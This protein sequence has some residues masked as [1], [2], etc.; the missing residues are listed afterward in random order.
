LDAGLR[1]SS[2]VPI[3]IRKL[4]YWEG[5]DKPLHWLGSSLDDL[6]AFP[7]AAR[8]SAGFE[9]R[10]LQQGLKPTDWKP[11]AAVGT[12]VEEIRIHATGAHRVLYVARFE[13]AVYVLHGFE[14]KTRRAPKREIEAARSRLRELLALRRGK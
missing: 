12:G 6:R 11:M 9:L 1:Q 10:R 13:E 4:V 7:E 14:K 5:V 8:R 3:A 2:P